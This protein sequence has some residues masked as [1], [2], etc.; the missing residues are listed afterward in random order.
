M[1]NVPARKCRDPRLRPDLRMKP[2]EQK[3]F[4]N[5]VQQLDEQCDSLGILDPTEAEPATLYPAVEEEK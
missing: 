2:A 1:N 4:L 3:I 5:T